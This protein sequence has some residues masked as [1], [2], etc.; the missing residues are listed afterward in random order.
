[1]RRKKD[2]EGKSISAPYP[3]EKMYLDA[4]A[5]GGSLFASL[6]ILAAHDIVFTIPRDAFFKGSGK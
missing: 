5:S 1:M 4:F 2:E 6:G 3:K